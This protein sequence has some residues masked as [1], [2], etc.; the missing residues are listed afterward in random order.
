MRALVATAALAACMAPQA[1]HA[2]CPL[3]PADGA[4]LQPG[5]VELA[6]RAEPAP[7]VGQPFVMTVQLCP[8]HAQLVK[9][10]ATMPEHRHGMNYRP[11][12]H[13][14]G[15]GRW[16]VEGLL[17]HM[18]GRW[19]LRWD[20]RAGMPGSSQPAAPVQVLRTSVQLQ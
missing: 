18:P 2:A 7:T 17:W 20:V 13:P 9:V 14:L 16:R 19:E 6:W 12:L 8:A 15:G 11:T 10:D 1:G 5:G 3:S 4:A